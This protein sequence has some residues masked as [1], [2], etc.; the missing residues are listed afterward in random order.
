MTKT[1]G[2]RGQKSTH[3]RSGAMLD[4]ALQSGYGKR[5]I[6][7]ISLILIAIKVMYWPASL[8]CKIRIPP[9]CREEREKKQRNWPEP[10]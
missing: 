8:V 9:G 5:R 4:G 3:S 10:F 6:H 1:G 7:K 2:V